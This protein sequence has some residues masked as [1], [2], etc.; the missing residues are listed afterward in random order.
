MVEM[1]ISEL[2]SVGVN[3]ETAVGQGTKEER[4]RIPKNTS[5]II[6]SDELILELQQFS[7]EVNFLISGEIWCPD[8]QLNV[9]ILKKFCDIN[10]NFNMSIITMARGKKFLAPLLNIED[11]KAPT[12][13]IL[14]KDMNV[15]GTFIERPNTVATVD[16]FQDIKIDYYKGKY[17]LDSVND[18]LDIIRKVQ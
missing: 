9:S 16:N 6:L 2:F 13:V 3:F 10:S 7:E 15:L 8:F 11:F 17:L 5:R 18:F 14:D 12:I 1:T 4:A